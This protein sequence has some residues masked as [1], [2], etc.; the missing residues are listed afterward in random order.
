L[1]GVVAF[2]SAKD[3]PGQNNFMP[4]KQMPGTETEQIFADSEI[5]FHNQPVGVIVAETME[6]AN[7]AANFV[8]ITYKHKG[9]KL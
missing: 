9:T 5:L 6:L 3:I 4:L 7:H 8:E 2:F 1:P